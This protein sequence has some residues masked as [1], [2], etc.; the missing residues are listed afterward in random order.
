MIA[1]VDSLSADAYHADPCETPS[2]SASIGKILVNDS[3]MH[4]HSAHPRLGGVHRPSTPSQDLGTISHS[5]TLG[6][7]DERI[8]IAKDESGEPFTSFN[9]KAAQAIR[10]RCEAVGNVCILQKH[11]DLA[12]E[13]SAAW[14]RQLEQR[15]IALTGRGEVSLFWEERSSDGTI[16]QCRGR[17]DL[18]DECR[19]V[20]LKSCVRAHP[21]TVQR[22]VHEFGYEIQNAAYE[23][24]LAKIRPE[25]AGRTKYMWIFGETAKPYVLQP[26]EP[27]GSMRRLGEIKW[28]QAID[29][30]AHCLRTNRWPGYSEG[31]IRLEASKWELEHVENL[32]EEETHGHAA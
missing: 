23:S 22:K 2:L 28:R 3:P 1:I 16:V 29:M 15:R 30:W 6:V 14:L 20:D 19:I 8:V 4:A 9:K 26:Y 7:P 25:Y 11:Y 24:A 27:A 21:K 17:V 18:L 12:A 13:M 10:D 31:T 5:L 32:D